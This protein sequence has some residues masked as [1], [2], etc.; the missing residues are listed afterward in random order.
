MRDVPFLEAVRTSQRTQIFYEA[1]HRLVETLKDVVEILGADRRVVV[2]REVT[3]LHEEFLRG[4]AGDV[5][6]ALEKRDEVKGEITLLIAKAEENPAPRPPRRNG[7]A[8]RVRELMNT[9]DVGREER[10]EAGGKR[11]WPFQ[12]R[13]LSRMAAH[14]VAAYRAWR[15]SRP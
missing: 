12:E 7:I 6:A 10:A 14:Q 11:V 8:K 9:D 4:H 5:L 2:G 15:S 1:P 3:K 13:S